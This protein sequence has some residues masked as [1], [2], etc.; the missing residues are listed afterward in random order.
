MNDFFT[1]AWNLKGSGVSTGGGYRMLRESQ[2]RTV[3]ILFFFFLSLT[4]PRAVFADVVTDW[5]EMLTMTLRVAGGGPGAQPCLAAMVSAAVFDA[6]NGIDRNYEPYFVKEWAPGG[7]GQEAAAAQAAY[8]A[9]V[10]LY[11][12]QKITFDRLLAASLD[13]IPGSA[14]NSQSV[15]RGRAWGEAV[16]LAILEWRSHDGF[17]AVVPPY[18]GE[19]T[20]GV[21]RSVPDGTLPAANPERRFMLP[22]AMTDPAQFRP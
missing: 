18:F 3:F 6:V 12:L 4:A 11:P 7:A 15:A 19:M 2:T 5:N 1:R 14:G 16:A 22:F 9:L 13:S 8:T 17:N 21:W 10:N 20:P